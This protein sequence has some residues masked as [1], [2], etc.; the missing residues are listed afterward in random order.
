MPLVPFR[1]LL[2]LTR[3]LFSQPVAQ[4]DPEALPASGPRARRQ[5]GDEAAHHRFVLQ[6]VQPGLAGLM[7]GS[8]STLAPIFATAFA[9]HSSHT[10]FLVGVAAAVGAGISMGFAEGLSDDGVLTGRG[11]PLKRGVVIALATFLGGILH[12]LPFLIPNLAVALY[13][14]YAVVGCELVAIAFIRYR[15]FHMSFV[16]SCVQVI[17]GGALVFIAGVLIGST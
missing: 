16:K 10:A 2:T 9:T 13:A 7:D 14:A 12:T 6:I 8:V 17:F 4:V 3:L 1:G 11:H 15:Y 5:A